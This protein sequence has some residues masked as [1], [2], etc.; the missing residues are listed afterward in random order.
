M[1]Y[2]NF[3]R[4]LLCSLLNKYLCSKNQKC[5]V[6]FLA[7]CEKAKAEGN[8]K[9]LEQLKGLDVNLTQYLL[10]Q[11]PPAVSQELRIVTPGQGRSATTVM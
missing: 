3:D 5:Y 1:S 4:D 7:E 10:I 2:A 8:V 9:F 6:P 11:A